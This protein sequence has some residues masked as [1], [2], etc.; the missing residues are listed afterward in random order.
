M[1]KPTD[2]QISDVLAG[3][4]TPEEGRI[5]ARWFATD[6]GIAYLSSS[7][8][9]DAAAVSEDDAEL[10]VAH[11][12]PSDEMWVEIRR[13][14][15]KAHMRQIA[16]R[17]AAV[18][19]PLVLLLGLY[20]QLDSRVDLFGNAGFED[21]YVPKGERLQLMFQDGTKAYVNSD[22]RLR[23]PKRFGLGSRNVELQGE[24]YFIVAKNTHRPFVVRL[25]GLSIQVVGTS[26]N[27]Q[28]YPEDKSIVVCLDEGKINML[29]PEGRLPVKPAQRAVYDKVSRRCTVAGYPDVALASTWKQNVI[30][31]KDACLAD[32]VTKLQRWY[33][34]EFIVADDVPSDLLITL[35]SGQT[36]LEKVLKDLEKIAPLTFYYDE[37]KRTVKVDY[38]PDYL[39]H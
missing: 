32:V 34:V 12:V 39:L 6:D 8:D 10:F 33:N 26:F 35:V 14:I 9:K 19:L 38:N 11:R 28:A 25:D 23:Y 22:T 24:A 2:K 30:T 29:L 5:V 27:V 13:R 7:F 3:M 21:I 20:F 15:R 4:A 31:F 18:L 36:I 16:F 1:E 37:L 17:V